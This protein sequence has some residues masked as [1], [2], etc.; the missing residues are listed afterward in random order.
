[1]NNG[2]NQWVLGYDDK[3]QLDFLN[4][5][6]GKN[7]SLADMVFWMMGAI[8]VV[9]AITFLVLLKSNK[10]KQSPAQQLYAQY[11]N[12][13]K[14][15]NLQPHSHEGALDFGKRAALALPNQQTAILEIA[16]CYNLLEYGQAPNPILLQTLAQLIKQLTLK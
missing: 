5:L 11:L 15:A 9:M 12:K 14:R 16:E 3:K 1:V 10:R 2:W 8:T 6:T 4:K 7:L 13:L